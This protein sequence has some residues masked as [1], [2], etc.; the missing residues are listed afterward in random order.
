MLKQIFALIMGS[1]LAAHFSIAQVYDGSNFPSPSSTY[2]MYV[3]TTASWNLSDSILTSPAP[4]Y[5]VQSSYDFVGTFNFEDP[6]NTNHGASFPTAEVAIIDSFTI[7]LYAAE[8]LQAINGDYYSLGGVVIP[9]SGAE[10]PMVYNNPALWL[11]LPVQVGNSSRDTIMGFITATG[12]EVGVPVDSIRFVRTVFRHDTVDASGNLS[13]PGSIFENAIRRILTDSILDSI[14]T[15]TEGVWA[16]D[17]NINDGLEVDKYVEWYHSDEDWLIA[18]ASISDWGV[19]FFRYTVGEPPT[20]RLEFSGLPSDVSILDTIYDFSVQALDI[21]NGSLVTDFMDSIR[22]SPFPDTTGGFTYWQID[23]RSVEANAGTAEFSNLSFYQPGTYQLITWSDTTLADTSGFITVHPVASHLKASQTTATTTENGVIPTLTISA[24]T[25]SNTVD[26]LYYEGAVRVGK[27]SSSGSL[28]GTLTQPLVNGVAVFDDLV[29]TNEGNHTLVFYSPIENFYL[30]QDTV[31]I[32]VSPNLGDWEF[33]KT[34]TLDQY[35]ERANEFV[36][37]GNADGYLSGTSRGG[38]S[39]VGQHFDFSG[40]A[41]LT[42]VICH[43]ANR[44]HVGDDTDTFELRVY[45]AGLL[46]SDYHYNEG[47]DRFIDSLPLSLIGSQLFLADSM[48]FGD[49]W[50]RNPTTIEFDN[51]PSITGDFIISLVGDSEQ[52]NDTIMLWHSVPG[53]ALGEGR[54]VRRLSVFSEPGD[55][56]W[57]RD[58]YWRPSFDVDLMISPILDIDTVALVTSISESNKIMKIHC[59]PN[60]ATDVVTIQWSEKGQIDAWL[61]LYLNGRIVYKE[62]VIQRNQTKINL[63]QLPSGIYTVVLRSNHGKLLGSEQIV[64]TKS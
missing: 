42:K 17:P 40:R 34:D 32:S 10:I 4:W 49:F 1:L 11:E 12:A 26:Q 59:L 57:L 7:D 41:E 31:E 3:D 37:F 64:K 28:R 19:R 21:G 56:I 18:Q 30:R 47:Q 36:W 29:I 13:V 43:F 51:P 50:I 23:A 20:V 53:D 54:T 35:V 5:F 48:H 6:I 39:E 2:D 14:Y 22:V 15:K 60:P 63:G 58:K 27:T 9:P 25:D 62:M 16:Y 8:Y 38:F 24:L 45:D 61:E 46:E 55:T 33:Q 44:F 52:S